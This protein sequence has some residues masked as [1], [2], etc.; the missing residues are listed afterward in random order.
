MDRTLKLILNDKTN[1]KV[2]DTRKYNRDVYLS[3]CKQLKF[4]EERYLCE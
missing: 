2:D 4:D 1:T 3:S